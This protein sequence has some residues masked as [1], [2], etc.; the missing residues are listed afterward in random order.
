MARRRDRHSS[1]KQFSQQTRVSA[2]QT[3]V[4]LDAINAWGYLED[5]AAQRHERI[6]C[7][8]PKTVYGSDSVGVVV[9]Y[10]QRGPYHYQHIG[11]LGVWALQV[12][13]GVRIVL[14]TKSLAFNAPVFNPESYFH[15][16]KRDYS[17]YYDDDGSP[18][19]ESQQRYSAIYD[20][21]A[22]LAIRAAL[23]TALRRWTKTM[24]SER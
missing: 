11:V 17:F 15:H 16:I 5:V 21:S 20:E 8:G 22:R 13:D 12:A 7:F 19:P 24:E 23:Q 2:T 9:W 3:G 10:K 6:H 18:P 14:G 4:V 1:D